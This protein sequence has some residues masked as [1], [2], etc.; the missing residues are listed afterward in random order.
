MQGRTCRACLYA[1]AHEH[2]CV[3]RRR[4]TYAHE[5]TRDGVVRAST[6]MNVLAYGGIRARMQASVGALGGIRAP[7]DPRTEAYVHAATRADAR[8]VACVRV[9]VRA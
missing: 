3:R 4:H 7:T 2:R 6:H 9:F 1:H 5:G 8:T